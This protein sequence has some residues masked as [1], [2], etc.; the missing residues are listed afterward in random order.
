MSS[1]DGSAL[2]RRGVLLVIASPSGAGKSTLTSLLLKTETNLVLSVS[3]TT[4]A[5]R[6]DEV[7]GVHYHFTDRRHFETMRDGGGLLEWA[8]V[9]GNLY[10]TPREPVEEALALGQDVLFDVDVEGVRQLA[11]RMR[12]DMATVFILPPSVGEQVQRLRRR[13]SD[14]EATILRRLATAQME[15]AAW[16]RFDYVLV[17][18]DLDRAFAGLQAILAAERLKRFRRP[19]VRGLIGE[20]DTDLAGLLERRKL[21]V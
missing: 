4:R 1:P 7:D 18:D 11:E 16:E 9:H 12:E 21:P 10:G 3:M 5:R 17:N 8:E 20:L 19:A 2:A 13:A 14:D 15:I 6:K